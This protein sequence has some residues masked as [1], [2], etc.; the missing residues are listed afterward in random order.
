MTERLQVIVAGAG[1]VGLVA[2]LKLAREGIAVRLID[3]GKDID[4]RMRGSTLH[5]PTLDLLDTLDLAAPLAELGLE[6]P[7]WQLRQHDKGEYV[8]F[9]LGILADRTRHPFQ[10]Q[11]EQHRLCLLAVDA[12][13][14]LGVEIE[15][16]TSVVDVRQDDDSVTVRTAGNGDTLSADWL[17]G[18]DGESSAVRAALGLEYGG[19]TYTHSSVLAST[20]FPFHEVFDDLPGIA[21]CWSL[22]GPFT[23]LRLKNLWRVSLS[24]RVEDLAEA[25]DEKHVREWLEYIHP[26]ARTAEVGDLMPYRVHERCINRF[27]VG[28]TCLAGDAAHQNPPTGGMGMNSGIHDALNLAG[29]LIEVIRGADDRLLDVYSRQRHHVATQRVIPQSSANRARM[30]AGSL[31]AQMRRLTRYRAIRKDPERYREFL[32]RTSMIASLDEA[33]GIE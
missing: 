31:D 20:T 10:L 21:Y 17:I 18:A 11:V 2:A 24:P 8:N 14:E 6:V 26:D 5:P 16:G 23:L 13:A 33:A 22:R 1:P 32:L 9:D 3:A 7:V 30:D 27:R 19:K 28:R 12:L 29:K 25:A 15:F 4:R